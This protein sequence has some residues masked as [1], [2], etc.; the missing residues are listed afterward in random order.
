M[1]AILEHAPEAR[2]DLDTYKI[3]KKHFNSPL[4]KVLPLTPAAH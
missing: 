1:E 4:T 2:F 3:L